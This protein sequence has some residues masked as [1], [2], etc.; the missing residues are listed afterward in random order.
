MPGQPPP[1]QDCRPTHHQGEEKNVADWIDEI[2]S[3]PK[4][5]AAEGPEDGVER[6]RRASCADESSRTALREERESRNG[7]R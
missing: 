5:V 6:E 4:R 1:R 7:L 3:D 2:D